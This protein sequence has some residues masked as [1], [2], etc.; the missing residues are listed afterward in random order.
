VG[1]FILSHVRG[2]DIPSRYG[3]DEFIIVLPDAS[4]AATYERA[5]FICEYAKQFQFK[6]KE[7]TLDTIT[8]SMG[9]AVYPEHG[10]TSD[11]ILRAVDTALYRA[12]HAGRGQV[13]VADSTR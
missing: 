1:S 5:E 10:V 6:L 7:Q 4:Q 2:E 12:K 3:G 11:A 9:V 8:I 13:A